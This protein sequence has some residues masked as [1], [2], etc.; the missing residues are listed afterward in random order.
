MYSYPTK[1]YDFLDGNFNNLK[2]SLEIFVEKYA[3]LWSNSHWTICLC[4]KP[5][6]NCPSCPKNN[7]GNFNHF[8]CLSLNTPKGWKFWLGAIEYIIFS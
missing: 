8:E 5:S 4:E 6:K 3:Y 2:K 7:V 1:T